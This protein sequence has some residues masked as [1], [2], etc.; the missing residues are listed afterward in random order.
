MSASFMRVPSLHWE[1]APLFT[2]AHH[3]QKCMRRELMIYLRGL[4]TMHFE[5]IKG[6]QTSKS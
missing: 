2:G 5:S 6:F 1:T 4:R 3:R